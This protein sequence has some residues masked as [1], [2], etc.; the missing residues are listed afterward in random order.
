[1]KFLAF[2]LLLLFF[3]TACGTVDP[4]NIAD[5][6]NS[7][8][9]TAQTASDQ[10]AARLQRQ[11]KFEE[12]VKAFRSEMPTVIFGLQLVTLALAVSL[13]ISLVGTGTGIG[14]AGFH[15]GRVAVRAAEVR[16]D[17]VHMDARTR[18]FP[19]LLHYERNGIYTCTNVNTGA[20]IQLNTS[21]PEHAELVKAITALNHDGMIAYEAGHAHNERPVRNVRELI[22]QFEGMVNHAK[23]SND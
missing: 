9:L 23:V 8:I 6:D 10:E 4:R 13:S 1:M 17:Q 3:L 2:F 22:N 11:V 21:R 5:A 19:L 15:L 12:M 16:A 18:T 7:R 20:V 14:W